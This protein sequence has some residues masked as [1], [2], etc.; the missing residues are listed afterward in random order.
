MH[1]HSYN[2]VQLSVVHLFFTIKIMKQFFISLFASM[3]GF[4]ISL[5]IVAFIVFGMIGALVSSATEEKTTKVKDNSVLTI[6][7]KGL[8]PERSPKNKFAELLKGDDK[9]I[10]LD[11]ILA[12]IHAAKTDPKIK[13]ILLQVESPGAGFATIEEIRNALLDFK[14]STK[15][16]LSYS[17]TYSQKAYYLCSVADKIYVNPAGGIDWRGLS[18]QIMF[19]KHLLEKLDVNVQVFRHGKFKSAVE[20]LELD[21]MSPAN[22]LQTKKYIDALWSQ[23]LEGVSKERKISKEQLNELADKLMVRSAEDAVT[24]HLADELIYKDDLLAT[25]RKKLNLKANDKITSVAIGSYAKSLKPADHR[26][27]DEIAIIYAYGNIVPGEADDDNAGSERISKAIRDAR[28]DS[29]VK[30]IVLRVNSP[31][32]SALASEVMWREV[33]LAKKVKPVVVSMGDVAASGGYYISCAADA[34]VAQPNTITGS[35]GVFGLIPNLKSLLNNKLGLT[36][37][38]VNSNKHADMMTVSRPLTEEEKQVIQE[39]VEKIY[40]TF[41]KRVADGRHQSSEQIDSIG[42]GRVWSGT[43]AKQIGLVDELGGIDKAISLAAQKAKITKYT[44]QHLPKLKDPLDEIF[45][46]S[47]D[48]LQGH[49]LQKEL[50]DYYQL[51]QTIRRVSQL[52]GYQALLPYEL[53]I[54]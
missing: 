14:T 52:K 3:L 27:K 8:I 28:L 29:E 6:E 33:L 1:T 49:V 18:S 54:N 45:K 10:G 25:L 2:P 4:F 30:A 50:G 19:M 23:V 37:D 16:V 17:E 51:L 34:I 22:R 47:T 20:P 53:I 24:H 46:E 13:G 44:L 31:G 21:K 5:F 38:T 42:Q 43:D 7:L 32:G 40:T 39:G 35:I 41:L 26:I 15:F 48:Q 9:I 36:F 11:D 12:S